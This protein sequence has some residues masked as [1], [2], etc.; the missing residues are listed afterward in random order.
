M[1]RPKE[2]EAHDATLMF[3]GAAHQAIART[4][5]SEISDED[6]RSGEAA[7]WRD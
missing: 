1:T 7:L 4:S 6:R 3:E 5:M 2:G